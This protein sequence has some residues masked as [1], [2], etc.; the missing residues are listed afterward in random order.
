M[1]KG[2]NYK[3]NT[4]YIHSMKTEN[5][6]VAIIVLFIMIICS[7]ALILGGYIYDKLNK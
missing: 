4:Y 7:M 1:G 5:I 3:L 6:F 2:K